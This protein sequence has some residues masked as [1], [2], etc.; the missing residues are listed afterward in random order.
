MR[1]IVLAYPD[2]SKDY[3]DKHVSKIDELSE[4]PQ[5]VEDIEEFLEIQ[6][7]EIQDEGNT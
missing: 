6:L 4:I 1:V 7:E 5:L 2:G 3:H